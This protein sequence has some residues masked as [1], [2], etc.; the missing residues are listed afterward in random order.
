MFLGWEFGVHGHLGKTF[1]VRTQPEI[2]RAKNL[3]DK[4][5]EG[6]EFKKKK[7]IIRNLEKFLT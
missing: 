3:N 6:L 1:V 2:L 4:M 5:Y 7:S